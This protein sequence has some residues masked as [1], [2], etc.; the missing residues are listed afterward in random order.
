MA[1]RI[2]AALPHHASR[3]SRRALVASALVVAS[4]LTA[5]SSAAVDGDATFSDTEIGVDDTEAAQSTLSSQLRDAG[6]SS[7]ATA[8]DVVDVSQLIDTPEFTLLVPS[9]EAFQTMTADELGDLL[10]DPESLLRVLRNHVVGER[11]DAAQLADV[12]SVRTLADA[13]LDVTDDGDTLTID[14]ATASTVDLDVDN[15]VVFVV[16]RIFVP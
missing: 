11:L 10:A 12:D 16:D 9:D 2:T 13:D 5:C 7:F 15:G 3:S 8:L 4:V 14:G 6:F 1:K